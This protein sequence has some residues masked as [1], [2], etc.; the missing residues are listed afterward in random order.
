MLFR[1]GLST[2]ASNPNYTLVYQT[3]G[4]TSTIT[5]SNTEVVNIAL[6]IQNG[7]VAFHGMG[8]ALIPANSTFYLVGQ[9]NL[10]TQEGMKDQHHV[11]EK[12]V[13][14]IANFTIKDLKNAMNTVPDLRSTDL[15]FGL[16][17]NLKWEDGA[18]FNVDI[19]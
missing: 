11:F 10:L 8:N 15:E 12:N 16:S 7:D 4:V 6:E 1:S 19:N 2:N 5:E 9:L 18:I 13:K 14:T 17:V 3:K